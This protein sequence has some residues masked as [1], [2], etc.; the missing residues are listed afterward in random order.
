MRESQFGFEYTWN[1]LKVV[2][3]LAVTVLAGQ[4]IGA[5]LG[6][7]VA[8]YAS[9]FANLWAGAAIATFP[10]FLLGLFIQHQRNPDALR[11]NR[12][13]V[14]RLGLIALVLSLAVFIMPL[15]RV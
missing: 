2:R 9:L 10:C 12:T 6:V 1:D 7:L 15:G 8:A 13:M 4:L 14:R 5:G 3:P 11:E